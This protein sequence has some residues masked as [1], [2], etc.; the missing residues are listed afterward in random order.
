M[1]KDLPIPPFREEVLS[2]RQGEI[3][4]E[5]SKREAEVTKVQ[6]EHQVSKK[7]IKFRS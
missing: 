1:T 6:N 2:L 7:A 5:K 3:Q 4:N